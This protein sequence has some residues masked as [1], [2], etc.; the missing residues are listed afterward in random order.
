MPDSN[1]A[2]ISAPALAGFRAELPD[3]PVGA[4]GSR[5]KQRWRR[6][7]RANRPPQRRSAR[8]A[9]RLSCGEVAQHVL[10]DAAVEEIFQLVDGIDAAAGLEGSVLPSARVSV[11]LDVLTRAQA[12]DAGDR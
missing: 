12:G 4:R 3:Q 2:A 5:R 8:S 1:I 7:N 6:R 11:D 9:A 10:Q